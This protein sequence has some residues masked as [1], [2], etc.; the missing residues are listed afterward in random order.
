METLPPDPES[1]TS[2][3]AIRR[4]SRPTEY[5]HADGRGSQRERQINT[6]DA[7]AFEEAG[8]GTEGPRVG[9]R[10]RRFSTFGSG[11][12][13][14]SSSSAASAELGRNQGGKRRQGEGFGCAAPACARRCWATAHQRQRTRRA[15]LNWLARHQLPSGNWSLAISN[16]F[17][18]TAPAP[19]GIGRLG[20]GRHGDGAVAVSAAGKRTRT[21]PLQETHRSRLVLAV[22]NK[23]RTGTWPA[24]DNHVH[25]RLRRFCMCGAYALAHKKSAAAAHGNDFI[26]A[27][28]SGPRRLALQPQPAIQDTSVSVGRSWGSRAAS[29]PSDGSGRHAH[30]R[31][32]MAP[33]HLT[34]QGRRAV[35]LHAR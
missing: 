11:S 14:C 3:W 15:A 32:Q 20:L 10:G 9:R 19:Q 21:R 28:E 22:T 1:N 6:T 25:P 33:F 2:N 31:E 13:P 24:T 17:A 4:S 26:V 23:N 8:G 5:R 7:D 12:G 16:R 30:R 34:R 29:W 27:A 18:R 35:L